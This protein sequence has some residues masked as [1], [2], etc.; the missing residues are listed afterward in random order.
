MLLTIGNAMIQPAIK[1]S[2]PQIQPA[3]T[4]DTRQ[5]FDIVLTPIA[6]AAIVAGIGA[7][8]IYTQHQIEQ[9]IKENPQAFQRLYNRI[10]GK[11]ADFET[12]KKINDT[13][14]K[15][16]DIG[17]LSAQEQQLLKTTTGQAIKETAK[18]IPNPY[19]NATI[20]GDLACKNQ[21]QNFRDRL[22]SPSLNRNLAAQLAD[23]IR[24]YKK[25]GSCDLGQKSL[26]NGFLETL[27]SKFPGI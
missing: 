18:F 7:V 10:L 6:I 12:I 21:M 5:A 24:N 4:N 8:G 14:K 20:H 17:K 2:S 16:Q 26:L 3:N 15:P 19:S 11:N 13:V 27:L 9:L 1:T 22:D 25:E 23:H